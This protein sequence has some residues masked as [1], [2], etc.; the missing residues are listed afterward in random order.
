MKK[1]RIEFDLERYN[2]GEYISLETRDGHSARIIC[3]DQKDKDYPIVVL[4]EVDENNEYTF[5]VT[6]TG[7]Y[8]IGVD[9]SKQ[10]LFMIVSKQ[11]PKIGEEY[12]FI[13]SNG[14]TFPA[15][16]VSDKCDAMRFEFGNFF[17]TEEEAKKYSEKIKKILNDEEDDKN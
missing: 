13:Q 1:E 9:V 15:T 7:K 6:K 11:N 8:D 2:K 5:C 4:G 10:D 12:W 14:D 16:F 17:E 3:T